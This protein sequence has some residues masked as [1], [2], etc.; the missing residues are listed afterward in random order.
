MA[1]GGSAARAPVT[2]VRVHGIATGGDGVGRLPDGL[3]VFVPRAAPG[4]LVDVEV[5]ER[6]RRFARGRIRTVLEASPERAEPACLHFE[7]DGCGGCQLQH[8]TPAAQ[9]AGKRTIVRD[10]LTRVGGRQVSVPEVV[11]A[12]EPWRYRTKITVAVTA[13][14]RRIG[15]RRHDD[16]GAIFEVE[17][18]PVAVPAL[19][20]LLRGVRSARDCL[21]GGVAQVMLRLDRAGAR[22]IV[23]QGGD[24]PWDPRP[25][26]AAFAPE[27]PTIWWQPADGAVRAVAG[28]DSAFPV[29]AFQQ[30]SPALA[31]RIREEAV[32]W[33]GV[34]TGPGTVV[35]DLYGGVGDNARLLAA[36]GVAVW[37]VDADRSAV[38]WAQS[39]GPSADGSVR[40]LAARVEEVLQRLPEPQAVLLNP[41]RGG[42]DRR[43]T[44]MLDRLGRSGVLRRIAYVSCDPATLARDLSRLGAFGLR[45]VTA[46]DLFPQTAHIETLALLE[47]A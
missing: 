36:T 25:L 46:Y 42:A 27:S 2:E 9:L 39:R 41:P 17:D 30:V 7:R 44:E 26:A 23:V 14:R 12:P 19:V 5:V 16:P 28:S 32:A 29:L 8:L 34:G 31:D 37:S 38:D 18:C 40:Y 35:W 20:E 47:T 21:P 43:V 15:F 10:V 11:P 13:D 45:R 3:A 22:H 4:D 1:P 33:L 24:P 6:R